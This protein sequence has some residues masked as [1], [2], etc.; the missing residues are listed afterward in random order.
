MKNAPV[1]DDG[2]WDPNPPL[3]SD[4]KV[5]L[6]VVGLG[7]SGLAAIDEA[8]R[9]GMTVA[10][11]EKGMI[12]GQAAG[13]NGGFLL[14][15]LPL[16]FHEAVELWG[17]SAV[18]LYRETVNELDR[19]MESPFCRSIGSV[20]VAASEQELAD[21]AR[22]LE[23]LRLAGF[24][25]ALYEGPEGK[26]L[27]IPGDGVFNPLARWRGMAGD[28]ASEGALLYENTKAMEWGLGRVRTPGGTIEAAHTIIA[29]DGR[30]EALFPYLTGVRTARLEM[31]ATQPLP[32]LSQHAV[33]TDFGY[34]YWQQLPD[35]RLALGGQRNYHIE[36]SW[37]LEPGTSPAIQE[38]LD[39]YLASQLGVDARVTHRWSGHAAFTEDRRPVFEQPEPGVVVIGGYSGHGNVLGSL[40]GRS[41]VRALLSGDF[42]PPLSVQV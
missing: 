38:S 15:G 17:D 32:P 8:L 40:Y 28:L 24:D 21:I 7:G 39:R 37:T 26:G 9:L 16:F 1:W 20:R 35:G 10:G 11:I 29:V 42:T 34:T 19:I 13:R 33:Y 12:A 3:A 23:A 2:R 18:E 27:R 5:D 25:A 31:L 14:A 36:E 4:L 41:A 22:E 6:C 30:L